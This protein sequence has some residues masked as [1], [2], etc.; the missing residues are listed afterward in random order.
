MATPIINKK[1]KRKEM[2]ES[3]IKYFKDMLLQ[4][5][6]QI[7]KNI[8]DAHKEIQGLSQ[9]EVNDEIDHATINIDKTIEHAISSQQV[10][11]LSEIDYALNKIEEG[12][13]G[14]CEMC[15]EDIKLPRLKVKPQAKYCIVCREL[16]EKT[17]KR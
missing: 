16:I 1:V 8:E 7:R 6:A 17:P 14:I 11:E 2:H 13:Y 3:D 12:T 4:R 15:E 9:S 5:K 10:K